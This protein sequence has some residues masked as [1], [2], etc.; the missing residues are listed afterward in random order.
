MKNKKYLIKRKARPEM[1]QETGLYPE[2]YETFTD[3]EDIW[4]AQG[5]PRKMEDVTRQTED[6]LSALIKEESP[7]YS[8]EDIQEE[9]D[10]RK[11]EMLDAVKSGKLPSELLDFEAFKFEQDAR[12]RG[13]SDAVSS[14]NIIR[15]FRDYLEGY[16]EDLHALGLEEEAKKFHKNFVDNLE[17]ILETG[18]KKIERKK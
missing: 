7:E 8:E 11:Q 13:L 3:I 10:F 5:I 2:P 17:Q 12:E 1:G 16:P 14:D 6:P 18:K 15:S 4:E 9:I